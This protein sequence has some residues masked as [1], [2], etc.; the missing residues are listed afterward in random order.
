MIRPFLWL[1][2]VSHVSTHREQS[3]F[4]HITFLCFSMYFVAF[5]LLL[6]RSVTRCFRVSLALIIV[7]SL[8]FIVLLFLLFQIAHVVSEI[9]ILNL[10]KS[11]LLSCLYT[12]AGAPL[13]RPI[14][15][16]GHSLFVDLFQILLAVSHAICWLLYSHCSHRWSLL[17]DMSQPHLLL[18]MEH[19]AFW[20]WPSMLSQKGPHLV[21]LS[22]RA[23]M[24]SFRQGRTPSAFTPLVAF[25]LWGRGSSC[26]PHSPWLCL[27]SLVIG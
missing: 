16:F 9:K 27:G 24:W 15:I 6:T 1:K 3:S 5:Q 8:L 20:V 13:I 23:L 17:S 12:M 7:I 18:H 22:S 25:C 2:F 14:N 4:W 26:P 21:L 11:L 19:D 10:C